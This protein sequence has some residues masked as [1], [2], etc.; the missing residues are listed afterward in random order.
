MYTLGVC[1][2][3]R[4]CE[5]T[6]SA[7]RLADLGRE[8]AMNVKFLSC[9]ATQQNVDYYWDRRVKKDSGDA[10][11]KWAQGC[12]HIVWFDGNE[13]T[14]AK[15]F[16]VSPGARHWYVPMW[17]K[18][19]KDERISPHGEAR[20]VC[21][22]RDGK[23]DLASYAGGEK[24]TW[25]LWDSGLDPVTPAQKCD[26]ETVSI[27][28]PMS[29]HAI[30]ETGLLVLR[31]ILDL[32][33]LFPNVSFTVECAKSWAKSGR[34]ILR[35]IRNECGTRFRFGYGLSPLHHVRRMHAHDWTWIPSTRVNTGIV[36]Q[37]SLACGTPV[38]V[39]NV[40]PHSEFVVD[41]GNGLLMDCDI[42]SNWVGAPVAG[43]RFI[44]V[45]NTLAKAIVGERELHSKCQ[46]T[47]A[48]REKQHAKQF[49]LFWA[50][51]WG[52]V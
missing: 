41:G 30:D 21:P 29:S 34:S 19:T 31:A 23:S 13:S 18:V 22:S 52:V 37:R 17:H 15:A 25:C 40:S 39:Y 33:K 11:Y 28:V 35:K 32:V 45:V 48:T 50:K 12:S 16:L 2:P 49:R 46:K 26:S 6:L 36:A 47:T 9:S 14:Y 5:T 10:V 24:A 20:L 7:V 4:R 51:E 27:Y 3:Y 8:L 38:I 44:S 1:A 43:P 42:Y